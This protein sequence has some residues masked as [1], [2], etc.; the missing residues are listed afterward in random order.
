[1]LETPSAGLTDAVYRDL[2]R[3]AA[4]YLR[5]ERA[6][7]T[8][9]PTALVHETWIR[10]TAGVEPEWENRERFF[11][12]AGQVMRHVLVDHAR[13]HDA[14]K[15]LDPGERLEFTQ[16]CL[17]ALE[18]SEELLAIDEALG[19]LE[20]FDPRLTQIVELRFFAGLSEQEIAEVL[21]ISARTV[22][23]EW[24]MAKAWLQSQLP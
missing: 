11:A 1:M 8:L 4:R 3:M 7:H 9:Q 18:R 13:K 24:R 22:R 15:R 2:R 20:K 12:F 21:E 14:E 6:D 17:F 19:R 16:V 5:S 10:M 23:R